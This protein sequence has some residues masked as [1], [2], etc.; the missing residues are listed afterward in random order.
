MIVRGKVSDRGIVLVTKH[1]DR[2]VCQAPDRLGIQYDTPWLVG[3]EDGSEG[4]REWNINPVKMAEEFASGNSYTFNAKFIIGEWG[5][6]YD[7]PGFKVSVSLS[8]IVAMEEL[9]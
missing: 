5:T 1:G 7:S 3:G 4:S 9:P 2:V 8:D 6:G